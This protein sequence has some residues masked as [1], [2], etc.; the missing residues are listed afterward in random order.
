MLIQNL[1]TEFK[2]KYVH[3]IKNTVIAFANTH[4]GELF[5]G[6]QDD[7]V[8][9]GVSD[10]DFVM[11]QVICTIRDTIR[12]DVTLFTE[13][14]ADEMAGKAVV[15][16]RVQRGTARPY[17]LASKG[18]RP[19]G[20][21]LRQGASTVPASEAA[22]LKM[23]K[24]T[25]GDSYEDARALIQDLTF[26]KTAAYFKNRAIQFAISQQRSMHFVGSDGAFTNVALLLSDQC[27]H[28]IKLAIFQG[29][30]KRVFLDRQEFSGSLLNQLEAVYEVIDRH[31]RTR[32]EFSGLE[33]I[34]KRDYPAEAIR[35][36]LL[37]AIIHRDYAFRDSTLISIF[38]DRIELVTIGGLVGGISLDDIMLGV[39]VLR[40]PHLAAVFYRLHLIEA[41][42]T[43]IAKM[44][45][46]YRDYKTG[47][48]VDVTG[49]AFKI[50]L[51]NTNASNTGLPI[52]ESSTPY[53]ALAVPPENRVSVV[54][55]L[56]EHQ[57]S[58]KRSDVE[59]AL[60]LSQASAILV[61]RD[62]VEQRMLVKEGRGRN[63]RYR[64]P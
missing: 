61:L 50:T 52:R 37:N 45:E 33:R 46:A 12:P 5:I 11:R 43:G 26:E 42:G 6:V 25:A 13:C 19:E 9:C 34:D 41:Y 32:A 35:E 63:L 51:P 20:V 40:N 27:T 16:V 7:G 4:G 31:N 21:Y 29:E 24:E 8:V 47:P 44:R 28:T 23:I 54:L 60:N 48:I 2:R 49:H 53:V 18:V 56:F 36:A 55:Q 58:I 1:T 22:I 15:V 14:T 64:L 57:E 10:V 62:M 30:Q 3:D 17:Y 59:S 39:S 38:D